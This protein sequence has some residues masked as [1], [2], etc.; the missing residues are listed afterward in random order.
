M[1]A[2]SRPCALSAARCLEYCARVY[3]RFVTG[4][5]AAAAAATEAESTTNNEV[6]ALIIAF[7]RKTLTRIVGDDAVAENIK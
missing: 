6:G 1:V 5:D 2:V 7:R 4:T 3:R